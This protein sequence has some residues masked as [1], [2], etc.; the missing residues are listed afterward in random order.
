[1]ADGG[2]AFMVGAHTDT[3]VDPAGRFE[4]TTD[5]VRVSSVA[6]CGRTGAGRRIGDVTSFREKGTRAR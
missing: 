5:Q 4:G 1:M 6:R 3:N 2:A